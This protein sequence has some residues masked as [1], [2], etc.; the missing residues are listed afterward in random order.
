MNQLG[1]FDVPPAPE[2][3]AVDLPAVR[4][5]SR[6]EVRYRNLSGQTWTGRGKPPRWVTDC[7]Q[8]GESLESLR[9]TEAGL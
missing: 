5:C 4:A 9:V 7:I 1:L 6:S 3:R 2:L 8:R